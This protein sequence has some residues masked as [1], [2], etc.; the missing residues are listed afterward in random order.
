MIHMTLLIS[1]GVILGAQVGTAALVKVNWE[2]KIRTAEKFQA[3]K[4]REIFIQAL[5]H[6]NAY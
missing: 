4:G 6:S 2:V 5:K 3:G 1:L